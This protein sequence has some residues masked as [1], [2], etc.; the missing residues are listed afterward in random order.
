MSHYPEADHG[1]Y[2]G[3]NPTNGES[4]ENTLRLSTFFSPEDLPMP[5]GGPEPDLQTEY[6]WS[7]FYPG[8]ERAGTPTGMGT[9]EERPCMWLDGGHAVSRE[10]HE[11]FDGNFKPFVESNSQTIGYPAAQNGLNSCSYTGHGSCSTPTSDFTELHT[12]NGF[13]GPTERLKHHGEFAERKISEWDVLIPSNEPATTDSQFAVSARCANQ[14]MTRPEIATGDNSNLIRSCDLDEEWLAVKQSPINQKNIKEICEKSHRKFSHESAKIDT[15]SQHA[16]M[17]VGRQ[18]ECSEVRAKNQVGE[19][20]ETHTKTL[21][22]AN[23]SKQSPAA[24]S[25]P[26]PEV[27][28]LVDVDHMISSGVTVA[29]YK[30]R[31]IIRKRAKCAVPKAGKDVC[32]WEKRRKNNESARRS[33]EMKKEKEKHF[34]RRALELEYENLFLKE[35]IGFLETKLSCA[36]NPASSLG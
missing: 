10:T 25:E 28:E 35:R 34:Y 22:C 27:K 20:E 16:A 14:Q 24:V 13:G 29:G 18:A 7:N 4:V 21:Q 1:C 8:L 26:F 32:Y 19:I 17:G 5:D 12:V 3:G 31:N 6:S 30:P 15:H 9:R 2:S 33:R 23:G 11:F 36:S